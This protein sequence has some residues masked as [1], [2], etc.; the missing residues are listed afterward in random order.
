MSESAVRAYAA[1]KHFAPATLERWLGL[2]PDGRDALLD[3]TT[4]LRL[5]ENQFRD[6]LDDLTAI[7]ARQATTVAAVLAGDEVGAVLGR[8]QARNETIK[9]LKTTLRRLRYPQLVA[10]EQRLRELARTLRLPAGVGVTLPENLEGDSVTMTLR[11]R[12]AAELRAQARAL[13][14]A[15]AGVEIEEMFAVLEGRW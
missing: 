7:A 2:P 5:G 1:N 10:A 6:L 8:G 14:T 13:T 11:G 4:R 9:G 15:L 12:S 3:L